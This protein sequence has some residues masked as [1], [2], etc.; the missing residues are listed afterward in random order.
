[1]FSYMTDLA[2]VDVDPKA[3]ETFDVQG[4]DLDSLLFTLMD[5]FL[6]RFATNDWVIRDLKIE[7]LDQTKFAIRVTGFGER[8]S[9]KKHT[10]GTE[11][12]AIT[13]SNMQI[14]LHGKRATSDNDEIR[15]RSRMMDDTSSS[16]NKDGDA[17][18]AEEDDAA[19]AA[20]TADDKNTHGADVYVIVDI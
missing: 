6:Y 13:Y 18:L 20:D 7:S 8:F 1:M 17:V 10:H 5:E 14:Y 19:A 12:K 3:T 16:S 9:L 11:V 4:H 2:K 15:K